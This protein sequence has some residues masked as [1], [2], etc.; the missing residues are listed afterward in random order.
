MKVHLEE[1]FKTF[2]N[3][4]IGHRSEFQSPYGV[5]KVLYADWIATGRLYGPIE[6]KIKDRL[7]PYLANTHSFSSET[8]KITTEIYREARAIIRK[9]VR[10]DEDDILITTGSGMTGALSRLIGI[11]KLR[12]DQ[13][14]YDREKPVVFITHMEHHSNHVPWFETHADVVIVPPGKDLMPCPEQLAEQVKKYED[15]KLKIGAFTACSNVTGLITN[16]PELASVMH[17]Y[18]GYC[19]VDFA[20]SAPYVDIHM[21][22]ENKGER[23]DAVSFSPHK[24]LGGPGACGILVFNKELYEASTP[25]IPGGGNVKWTT[26][27]GKH[28][29]FDA[30]E[31]REDAGTPGIIQT[32]RAALAIKLKE[33]LNPQFM[34][35]REQE[36]MDCFMNELHGIREIEFLGNTRAKRIGCISFNIDAVHYN[37]VVRLLNDRFGI[38]VRGGWSCASTYAHYLFGLDEAVSSSIMEQIDQGDLSNKPGWVR[39]S[40]HPTMNPDDIR[41]ITGAIKQIIRNKDEWQKDY[42]YNPSNNEFE[43]IHDVQTDSEKEEFFEL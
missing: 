23:L 29:Y 33:Q 11:L 37:L 36:L 38:Q 7:G 9:H 40:I 15:R 39:I 4:I 35:K 26:P 20:A 2:R 14:R 13:V 10:A 22:P 30:I 17:R 25:E 6:D 32:V 41:Y 42:E 19:F 28:A 5:Q 8:G 18:G 31:T 27:R 1:H 3:H 43:S 12:K 34:A 24:F 16:Y 21:H